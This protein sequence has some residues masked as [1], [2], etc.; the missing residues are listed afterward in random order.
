VAGYGNYFKILGTNIEFDPDKT[1]ALVQQELGG[2]VSITQSP[3]RQFEFPIIVND[4]WWYDPDRLESE[5]FLGV[6]IT[7]ISGLDSPLTR[8]P[9]AH[10]AGWGGSVLGPLRAKQRDLKFEAVIYGST[11]R[12]T[13][14]GKRA[15]I[16]A[17]RGGCGSGCSL[18]EVE[19]WTCCP[20]DIDDFEPKWRLKDTGLTSGP[21]DLGPVT[22][23]SGCLIRKI[24]WTMSSEQPWL[25]RPTEAVLV[26]EQFGIPDYPCM[27][28]CDW[29]WTEHTI[30]TV[31]ESF[32][33]GE[34][35]VILMIDSGESTFSGDFAVWDMPFVETDRP[36]YTFSV[37]DI[38]A[39]HSLVISGST[40]QI[41]I[42][43]NVNG[44]LNFDGGRYI[45]TDEGVPFRFISVPGSC[46]DITIRLTTTTA[47]SD[48][49]S[50]LTIYTV[51]REL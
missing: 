37:R 50:S 21:T 44:S 31:V 32:G 30:D 51:H 10:G 4:Q 2:I 5:E 16:D 18:D 39:H 40:D 15:I 49:L 7:K 43:N 9:S 38:P 20:E 36:K 1:A 12:G 24:E 3:C 29:I 8:Q 35:S 19:I 41:A 6:I 47:T 48:I 14:Y 42:I 28:V 26:N 25:Y 33:M 46:P 22:E 23:G 27:D 11:C 45:R 34:T 13:E 17:L